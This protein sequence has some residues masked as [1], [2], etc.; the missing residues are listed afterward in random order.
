MICTSIHCRDFGGVGFRNGLRVEISSEHDLGGIELLQ[1]RD[2]VIMG[3]DGGRC[4]CDGM[5]DACADKLRNSLWGW[6]DG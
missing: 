3:G 2:N 5:L 4:V 1:G 6:G